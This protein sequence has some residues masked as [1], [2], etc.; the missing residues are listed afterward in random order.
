MSWLQIS[1]YFRM[2]RTE[3]LSKTILK[4]GIEIPT[5]KNINLAVE[6]SEFVA[7]YGPSGSG[8]SSLVN[9]LGMLDSPTS[10]L[11]WINETE[12]SRYNDQQRT[13]FR[14]SII[15][16][17]FQSFNLLEELTVFKNV[18]LPLL[19]LGISDKVRNRMVNEAL[20][21]VNFPHLHQSWPAQLSNS[22]QQRVAI[23]RAIVHSPT[24]LIADEPVGN[25]D[26][27]GG[28]EI[29]EILTEVNNKGI[30]LILATHSI[31]EAQKA[32]R[33]IQLF[34]GEILSENFRKAI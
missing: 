15:G 25:L 8:K 28:S 14:K 7:I 17:V 26:S 21:K 10:G 19:Y 30:T 2:I 5:L 33:I 6:Q 31:A 13:R 4:Q 16:Y 3:N 32:N 34:D 9:I 23:A 24:L 18:E 29:M 1:Q 12:V 11:Y 20:E 22:Q 27:K